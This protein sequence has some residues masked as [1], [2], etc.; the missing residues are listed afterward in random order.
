MKIRNAD[1]EFLDNNR[2]PTAAFYDLLND[3]EKR[4][5]YAKQNTSLPDVPDY[6]RINEFKMDVNERIVRGNV[7]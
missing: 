7:T 4:F 1:P 3:Y 2:Q 6:K 5:E